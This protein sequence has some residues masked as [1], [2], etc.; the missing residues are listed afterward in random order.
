MPNII[1]IT[2]TEMSQYKKTPSK[3]PKGL[4]MAKNSKGYTCLR[5]TVAKTPEFKKWQFL[6]P[7]KGWL[8]Q[9]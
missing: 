7:A 5:N 8:T 2:E 9:Y 6:R 3:A 1:T 4:F